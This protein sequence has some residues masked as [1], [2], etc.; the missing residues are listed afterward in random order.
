MTALGF[1]LRTRDSRVRTVYRQTLDP[2]PFPALQ[3]LLLPPMG[4]GRRAGGGK[5]GWKSD[6]TLE[7]AALFLF[8]NTF[9][10]S[11]ENNVDGQSVLLE[12]FQEFHYSPGPVG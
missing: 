10:A 11:I 7:L 12:I 5:R 4:V 8:Q 1:E 2:L 6:S 3:N 9:I